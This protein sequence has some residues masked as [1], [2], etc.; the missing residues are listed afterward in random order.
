MKKVQIITNIAPLYVKPVWTLF[1]KSKDFQFSFLS[2][3]SGHKGIKVLENND[4]EATGIGPDINYVKN[5]YFGKVLIYQFGVIWNILRNNKDIYIFTADMYTISTWLA[6]ILCKIRKKTVFFWGHG[7]Y[8]NEKVVKKY[9]RLLFYKFAD[10]HFLYG[11]RAKKF[12]T[13]FGFDSSKL[14]VVY[15][16]LDYD[17]HKRLLE[18]TSNLELLRMKKSLFASDEKI[19]LI[20]FV[21]R[22]TK[23]KK[24]HQ[25]FLALH[26]LSR[27]G[28]MYNCLIVGDG[29]EKNSLENLVRSLNLTEHVY[30]FGGSYDDSITA[31]LIMMSDVCV[32]PG[33]VGLTAMHS[34]GLGTPV[35]THDN[36]N[37][38]MPEAE[39]IIHG[40]TGY[41][42][43]ENDIDSLADIIHH[44]NYRNI[45]MNRACI[46][47]IE[48]YYNPRNQYN[49]IKEAL[50]IV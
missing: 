19:P 31:K 28:L 48:K 36:F 44:G 2:S 45:T 43:K 18:T 16:S 41:L 38:Q 33:N 8:G 32:S 24:L 3:R 49:I 35:I 23:E 12:L 22:L 42:F 37:N 10:F 50:Q 47:I 15:N 7:Y 27:H 20:L 46:D 9:F 1:V 21:G 6:A 39:C 25:L 34:M 30:F 5:I 4:F 26:K 29:N 13:S 11:N 40:V 17:A 14:F